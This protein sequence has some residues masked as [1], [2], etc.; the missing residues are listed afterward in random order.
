MQMLKAKLAVALR[1]Q[2]VSELEAIRGERSWGRGGR[3]EL[4]FDR[5][6]SCAV[7]L[8]GRMVDSM[9]TVVRNT[10]RWLERTAAGCISYGC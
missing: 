3:E 7:G 9:E 4:L 1:E 5:Y 6:A 2:R 8:A 10:I